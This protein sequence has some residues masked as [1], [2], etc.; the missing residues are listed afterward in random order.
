MRAGELGA[1]L[2]T[3]PPAWAAVLPGWTG[4]RL[5]AVQ[6]AVSAVSGSRPIAPDDPL[7]ALRLVDP[8]GVKVVVIGQ[9]PYPTTGH[10]DGLAFSAAR[11]RP[12]SLARVFELLA[13]ARPGFTPPV[14]GSLDGWARQ[15]VLLLNPV[16]TVEVGRSGSHMNCGWQ[17]LTREIVNYL[18]ALN[19]PPVFMAWGAKAQT[20]WEQAK[21]VGSE[22][23]VLTT[24]HPSYDFDRAFMA[25]GNHFEATAHLVDWWEIGE[26][27]PRVL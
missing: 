21:E 14:D 13:A 8:E 5:A 9:D 1:A 24:R 4:E 26:A 16:L 23:A 2:A 10:A 19:R 18:S 6:A 7:R 3:L 17:A 27:P 22:A 25:E 11:G 20:F 15:G 12:R